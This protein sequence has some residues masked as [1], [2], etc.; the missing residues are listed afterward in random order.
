[1]NRHDIISNDSPIGERI[2]HVMLLKGIPKHK[3]VGHIAKVLD[4]STTQAHRK[5]KGDTQWEVSQLISVI[6]SLNMQMSAFFD[7][8]SHGYTAMH[9]A[10]LTIGKQETRCRIY[11]LDQADEKEREYSAIKINDIWHV[12]RTRDIPE[13]ALFETR[14]H[15]GMIEIHSPLLK[16]SLPRIAILDD[17]RIVVENL[18]ETIQSDNYQVEIFSDIPALEARINDEPFDAYILDWL[19]KERSVYN[20]IN[21]IRNSTLSDALIVVLTGQLGGKIDKEISNAINDF[22]ILGPY[23]KPVRLSVIKTVIN[24]YF[25]KL[26]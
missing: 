19:I 10:F 18:K 7:I 12:F 3:H 24:K 26:L 11:L 17:D 20:T 5:L 16:E 4:I 22:D 21:K 9:D 13:N 15:V 25:A 6:H 23:E 8:T 14:R 2:A 1:M